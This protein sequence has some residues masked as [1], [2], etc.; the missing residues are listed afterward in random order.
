MTL[1]FRSSTKES[2][3]KEEIARF[4]LFPV[5]PLQIHTSIAMTNLRKYLPPFY[6]PSALAWL[7]CAFPYNYDY[8]CSI[9]SG[10]YD[11]HGFNVLTSQASFLSH[12]FIHAKLVHF[13]ADGS[14]SEE[15]DG[16]SVFPD[17]TLSFTLPLILSKSDCPWLRNGTVFTRLE[18]VWFLLFRTTR[19]HS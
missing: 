11:V 15:G 14:R 4:V 1:I 19:M 7:N 6:R 17:C 5:F 2:L 8:I 18:N 16:A 10:P 3:E 9:V 13:Y 12:P